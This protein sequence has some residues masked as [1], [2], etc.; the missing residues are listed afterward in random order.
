[1]YGYF[2]VVRAGAGARHFRP[3]AIQSRVSA[4]PITSSIP[5]P[6]SASTIIPL[7]GP[8]GAKKARASASV[9]AW[10]SPR[11]TGT[12]A[13]EHRRDKGPVDG[14]AILSPLALRP[15]SAPTLCRF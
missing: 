15:D 2:F 4:G 12:D 5:P 6:A 3:L 14:T 11:I 9:T 13:V 1:M 7:P 8:R 10:P